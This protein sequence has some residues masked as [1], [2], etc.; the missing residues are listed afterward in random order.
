MQ[1]LPNSTLVGDVLSV[2]SPLAESAARLAKEL[3]GVTVVQKGTV[4]V[5]SNGEEGWSV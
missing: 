3:G 5:I 1:A 4:D 2:D